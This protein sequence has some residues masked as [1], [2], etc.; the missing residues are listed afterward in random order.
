MPKRV[1]GARFD[2]RETFPTWANLLNAF[3]DHLALR[4]PYVAQP[5]NVRTC[6]KTGLLR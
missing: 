4:V 6:F 1:V 3:P 2:S 5:N